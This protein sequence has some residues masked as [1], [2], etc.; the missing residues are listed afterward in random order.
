VKGFM[1]RIVRT[2]P[3][4]LRTGSAVIVGLAANRWAAHQQHAQVFSN[5]NDLLAMRSPG[6]RCHLRKRQYIDGSNVG[7]ILEC[8]MLIPGLLTFRMRTRPSHLR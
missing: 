3:F 5:T 7:L 8:G 6:R 4:S 1:S 2:T